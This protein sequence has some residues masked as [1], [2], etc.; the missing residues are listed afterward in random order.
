MIG[1]SCCVYT[2]DAEW[3]RRIDAFLSHAPVRHITDA[4]RLDPELARLVCGVLL[5]D[6]TS[7]RA[8]ERLPELLKA[9]PRIVFVACGRPGTAPMHD[10][11]ALGVY[12]IADRQADRREIGALVRRALEYATVREENRILR[13]DASRLSA[14]VDAAQLPPAGPLP[15]EVQQLSKAL[16]HFDNVEALL[17]RLADEVASALLVARVGIFCRSR[18][19]GGY[20]LRAGLRCVENTSELEFGEGDP[21]AAWLARHGHVV[22]R[23]NL[24]HVP[25]PATR[26]MLARALDQVGAEMI[27]PLQSRERLLGWLFVGHLSTGFPYER[28]HVENLIQITDCVSTTLENALLYEEVGIQKSLAETLLHSMPT[29]IVAADDKGIVRCFNDTAQGMLHLPADAVLNR[30]VEALGVRLADVL[31][32]TLGADSAGVFEEWVEP[33]LR[34]TF[35]VRTRRLLNKA[36]CLGAVAIVQDLTEQRRLRET[37]DRLDRAT[38]WAELAASMSHEVRNPLVA[39]KTF[40]QLLPERYGDREFQ[41]EFREL[42]PREV[43]RLNGIIDQINDFAN[44]PRPA[45][46]EVDLRACIDR[47]IAAVLPPGSETPIR[48]EIV[49]PPDLPRVEGDDRALTEAITHVVRNAVEAM[50]GRPQACLSVRA[51]LAGDALL[52]KVVELSIRDNGPGIPAGMAD[53]L[54]SPFATTKARGLGLGL[55]IAKRTVTDHHGRIH[56]ESSASGACITLVLPLVRPA[57]GAA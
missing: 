19:S 57:E 48:I 8:F 20:R 1:P 5:L 54:F 31:R 44:P 35:A 42:V 43:D 10:A 56:I 29:G 36:Q 41:T 28:A 4:S 12:A 46:S 51:R 17:H 14:R 55:P 7:D 3:L 27:V 32:R 18:D 21:L 40:A 11:E 50:A 16:R 49:T 39:I 23:A 38:F 34:R 13:E 6:L 53:K 2:T 33:V 15:M 24:E 45:W 25:D 26:M 37:Q 9:W 47:A 52:G 30:P 22:S